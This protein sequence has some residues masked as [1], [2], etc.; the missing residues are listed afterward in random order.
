[1]RSYRFARRSFLAG[2]GGAVGLKI[3]LRNMERA[4]AMGEVIPPRFL[5]LHWP[6]GTIRYNFKPSGSGTTYTTSPILK[7][8]E[9]AGLRED[10]IVLYGLSQESNMGFRWPGGGGHEG[11]TPLT[12]TGASSPGTRRNGGEGDDSSAGG[13]SWDQI[14]LNHVP[15]LKQSGTGYINTICDAR[16][17]SLETS[18]QC[19]S[20]AYDRQSIPSVNPGGNI[21]ENVPLLPL[22]NPIQSY[23]NLFGSFMPGGNTD[24]NNEAVVRAL[25]ARKSVLDFSLAELDELR[26][27]SPASQVDKIDQH[28]AAI[29]AVEGQLSDQIAE[30]GVLECMVPVEPDADLGGKTGSRFDYES[31]EV[32]EADQDMHEAVGMAHAAIILAAFSCDL[33]R[34]GTFQ[35]SPGTNHVS[36]AGL[37]PNNPSAIYMH[38]P[39]SH[40]LGTGDVMSSRP[41][42]QRGD[43][44]DFLTNVQIWYNE[45]TAQVINLFKN[46]MLADGSSMLDHTIMPFVTEV[47]QTGHFPR[48]PMP[49]MIFGG[50]ALGMQGGQYLDFESNLRPWNDFWV[51]I[52]QAY[53]KTNDPMPVFAEEVFVKDGVSPIEGLWVPV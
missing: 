16:V 28:A 5:M 19:L 2:I 34:V 3:L 40:Q 17:D 49:A 39:L 41:S 38:H 13:P 15:D 50:K 32:T 30:G 7:P 25:V 10:M 45:K 6:V 53:L 42:G 1:M 8:F 33:I 12:T 27:L 37:N 24:G 46:T 52:A 43:Y 35:W 36:F 21:T 14:L 11:G 20:Y 44:V 23:M 22:L 51:T 48:D 31:F 18:T 29:R 9:D 4:E 26:T 47:S